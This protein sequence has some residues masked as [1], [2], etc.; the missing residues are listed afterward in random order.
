MDAARLKCLSGFFSTEPI[1]GRE[2][3]GFTPD[4]EWT[5]TVGPAMTAY[6]GIDVTD[7]LAGSQ[8]APGSQTSRWPDADDR[9][10]I[11]AGDRIDVLGHDLAAA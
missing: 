10:P 4:G 8:R 3:T 1:L 2:S 5:L 9:Q 6:A 7:Y 11:V